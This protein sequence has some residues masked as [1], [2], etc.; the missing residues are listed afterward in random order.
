MILLTRPESAGL[1][2]RTR[3]FLIFLGNLCAWDT[4]L[5]SLRG[6]MIVVSRAFSH[7][8]HC[9]ACTDSLSGLPKRLITT[10]WAIFGKILSP[11]CWPCHSATDS[12]YFRQAIGCR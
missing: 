8:V 9:A 7:S 3:S 2:G 11:A 5:P 1:V 6:L 12:T 4:A 10:R